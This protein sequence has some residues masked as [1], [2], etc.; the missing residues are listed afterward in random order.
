M[1]SKINW[2]ASQSFN[3]KCFLSSEFIGK[4]DSQK[5]GGEIASLGKQQFEE[6]DK[7]NQTPRK[8]AKRKQIH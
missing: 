7:K 5:D 1:G 8:V 2:S 6:G 4:E 3:S